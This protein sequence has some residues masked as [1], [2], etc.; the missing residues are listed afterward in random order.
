MTTPTTPDAVLPEGGQAPP[1][2]WLLGY[3]QPL[4]TSYDIALLDLDGVCYRGAAPVDHAAAGIAAARQAGLRAMFV[5][6]NANR[7]PQEVADQLTSLDIPATPEEIM[8]AAQ[9]GAAIL[10]EHVPAGSLVLPVGGEGLRVALR[11]RG[12]EVAAS[13][14]EKPVAVIQGFN[15]DLGWRELSEAAL[16]LRA[17]AFYVATNLD[18]TL[19]LE[20]GQHLGNGALVA[21]VVHA[22][23]VTPISGGKPQAE[24]FHQAIAK[25]GGGTALA[26]GDR[27]NTDLRGARAADVPGLHV[28][29]GVSDARDVILAVPEE[30]PSFLAADMRGLQHTHPAPKIER[31]DVVATAVVRGAS[32]ST[33]GTRLL[34]A[35]TDVRDLRREITVD[36]WRALAVAAWASAD[37]GRPLDP[38]AVPI[39]SVVPDA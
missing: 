11:E 8:T 32:A 37:A 21:A 19:P 18:A 27:L 12:F 23:G 30:R 10:A 6:N 15:P 25:A 38:A 17:G 29:T 39:L 4:E 33:D 14:D 36:E 20:R 26:I 16:A 34:L 2:T 35:G 22:T 1:H 28:L 24:I 5:T 13:A 31:L 9:A 7:P 3:D